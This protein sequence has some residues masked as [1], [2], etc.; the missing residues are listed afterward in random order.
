LPI[1]A[2]VALTGCNSYN[3]HYKAEPQPDGANIFA[4]FTT[5][6]DAIGVSVDTDG[7]RLEEIYIKKS[8]G[9]L[10]RPANIAYPGFGK[11]ASIGTG[12]GVGGGSVGVGTGIFM[13]VGPERARGLTTATFA[14]SA[15]GTAPWELHVKVQ[16]IKEAIIPA[17]GGTPTAK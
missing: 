15:V 2:L 1:L 12:V 10:V 7:R 14:S 9:T 8:D 13:P 17:L 11:S 16:G 5:L 6:Q 3:L 4:D